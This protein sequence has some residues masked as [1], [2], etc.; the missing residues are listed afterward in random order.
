MG[1]RASLEGFD[2]P[3]DLMLHLVQKNKLNLSELDLGVLADQ[4]VDFIRS[5]DDDSLDLASEY[6]V[7]FASLLEIKSRR[8]LPRAPKEE[9]DAYM[10]DQRDILQK[11]LQEYQHYKQ[12]SEMLAKM[13]EERTL[14]I[15]R[16][17]SSLVDLWRK[18]V[19]DG[20]QLHE[21]SQ[22][23]LRAMER[24]MRRFALLNPYE[25]TMQVQKMS[26]EEKSAWLRD[27]LND[28]TQSLRF[29][30]LISDRRSA[31]DVVLT[32]MAL[33]ELIH[34]GQA[35]YSVDKEDV[36]WIRKHRN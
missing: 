22:S 9:E 2:G 35:D 24:V 15:D 34:D 6:M 31:Y 14:Q 25:T 19:E 13:K 21:S 16:P 29:E 30:E 8:L 18:P 10:E 17:V 33:L 36:L 1:F 27:Y 4:Y 20:S 32:F 28:H 5:V 12:M 11:R 26:L 3:L 23:L 7:E